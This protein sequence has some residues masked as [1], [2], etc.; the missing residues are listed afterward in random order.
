MKYPLENLK[1]TEFEELVALICERIL[2]MGTI[3]F[4]EGKDG[5]KDAK[6]KGKA[7][8]FPS[9]SEPWNGK[10]VI[11]AKHTS[12]TNS[13]CSESNFKSI[14]KN[15]VLPAISKLQ[16]NNE[17]DFYLLFTNRKLSGIQDTKIEDIFDTETKI[18]NRVIAVER[19]QLWLKE[20][21]DIAKTLKLNL[22]LM[23]LDFN[24][25]DIKEI[26]QSF[27]KINLKK[28]K[29][30]EIPQKRDIEYKNKLN[31]LSKVYFDNAIKKNLI[32]FNQIKDF[33]EDPINEEYL[34]KYQNTIDDINE[35]IIIHRDEYDK[36]E[37]VI[38]HLFKYVLNNASELH[39][40]RSFLRLFL[41]YMYYNCDIGI[42]E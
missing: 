6:F 11:Q 40:K 31:N 32:Y 28:S 37:E 17:I 30:S 24:E 13:S 2:G 16:N 41:H 14:I 23:P 27:S 7:N 10:V 21:P 33:L 26:V 35:E 36:F 42:N 34:N 25:N 38:N 19:I 1:D 9:E 15:E 5:G 3:V 12:R 20:F 4:S 18:E 22:L 29:L 39:N 8:K